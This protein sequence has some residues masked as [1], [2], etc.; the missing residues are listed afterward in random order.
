[1]SWLTSLQERWQRRSDVTLRR[2]PRAAAADRRPVGEEALDDA[3]FQ[4]MEGNDDE[5][6]PL[7]KHTFRGG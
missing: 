5:A 2:M 6:T 1:M 4:R 7:R 3:V